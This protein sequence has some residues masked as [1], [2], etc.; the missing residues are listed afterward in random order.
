MDKRLLESALAEFI[1]S[2]YV[3]YQSEM[4]AVVEHNTDL[5]HCI[6]L[7]NTNMLD[8]KSK[9][10]NQ[11]V[12]EATDIKLYPNNLNQE[13]GFSLLPIQTGMPLI[14]SLEERRQPATLP[15][16][17]TNI[18][19]SEVHYSAIHLLHTKVH[20]FCTDSTGCGP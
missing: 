11:L 16:F 19:T 18:H 1:L 12:Q 14:H 9:C 4:L 5:G 7:T 17:N 2:V 13:D 15:H 20:T 6:L 10:H 8:R 3:K